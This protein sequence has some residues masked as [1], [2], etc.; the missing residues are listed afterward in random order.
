[1]LNKH[2]GLIHC[3]GK[4]SL[5]Q[6]KICNILLFNALSE[7]NKKSDSYLEEAIM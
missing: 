7:I 1:M 2:I 6:R 5:L 3:E 4:L